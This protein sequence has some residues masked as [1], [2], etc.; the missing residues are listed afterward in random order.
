MTHA[1]RARPATR[2]TDKRPTEKR[3]CKT[4]VPLGGCVRTTPCT[5]TNCSD[6]NSSEFNVQGSAPK[7]IRSCIRRVHVARLL[8]TWRGCVPPPCWARPPQTQRNRDSS[9][10][11]AN[12]KSAQAAPGKPKKPS[13]RL[14]PTKELKWQLSFRHRRHL[15]PPPQGARRPSGLVAETAVTPKRASHSCARTPGQH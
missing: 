3:P 14:E 2:K 12:T 8:S 13:R 7:R 4:C 10:T 6:T 1:A 5:C 9:T 15:Q 11:R